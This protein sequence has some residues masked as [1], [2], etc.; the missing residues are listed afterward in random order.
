MKRF[1]FLLLIFSAI[2]AYSQPAEN[3]Y[4]DYLEE[5]FLDMDFKQNLA[6]PEVP[7]D[8]KPALNSY[9]KKT[10]DQ[11]QKKLPDALKKV[12][13]VGLVRNGEVMV[14]TYPAD[15]LFNPNDTLFSKYAERALQEIIPLMK[16]P[17]IYKVVYA[18]STDNTGSDLYRAS[19]TDARMNSI[20]DW[21]W[22]RFDDNKIPDEIVVIPESL[23][24]DEPV[25][26]NLT[27][28]NRRKNRRIDFYFVP[29]PKLISMLKAK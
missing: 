13:K 11:F 17:Y 7:D 16:D 26:D 6:T 14:V 8:L 3:P 2:A 9:M 15:E 18:V 27:R 4:P 23:S 22:K 20:Y 10:A 29:G 19:L 12:I 24:S 25:A 1:C 5:L 28:E 21:F